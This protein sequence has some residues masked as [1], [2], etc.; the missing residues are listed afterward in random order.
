MALCLIGL[1]NELRDIQIY[2]GHA[3]ARP[4]ISLMR[5]K[6]HSNGYF[7]LRRMVRREAVRP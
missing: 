1:N 7:D 5:F 4:Y 6:G 2:S 3:M